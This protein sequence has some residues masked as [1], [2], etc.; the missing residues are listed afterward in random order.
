MKVLVVG[1][2]RGLLRDYE[3]SDGP[4]FQALV[5]RVTWWPAN[6]TQ[7]IDHTASQAARAGVVL[8][9]NNWATVLRRELSRTTMRQN[10]WRRW[11][12]VRYSDCLATSD[13]WERCC[14][15]FKSSLIHPLIII[16]TGHWTPLHLHPITSQSPFPVTLAALLS[17]IPTRYMST[18]QHMC[19]HWEHWHG[20]CSA[21]LCLVRTWN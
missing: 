1:P 17:T 9:L 12:C 2:S 7:Q 11:S 3:P 16:D 14:H 13:Y 18:C 6:V 10:V 8:N 4:P 21:L 15:K 5:W 19:G 20:Q